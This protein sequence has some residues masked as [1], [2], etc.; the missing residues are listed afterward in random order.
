MGG[1][2]LP[3]SG[4]AGFA[5]VLLLALVPAPARAQFGYSSEFE[6]SPL[7]QVREPE[8]AARTHL[9]RI[10]VLLADEQWDE[11]VETL[12][13][14]METEGDR[15][16]ALAPEHYITVRDY[17]HLQIAQLPPP[18]LELY[19]DRVDPLAKQWYEQGAAERDEELLAR[20]VDQLFCSSWGDNAL[21]KLGEMALARGDFGRARA[22]WERLSPLLRAPDGRPWSVLRDFD[23]ADRWKELEPLLAKRDSPPKWL[24]FPDTEFPLADVRARLALVSIFEGSRERAV[25]ELELLR[26]LHPDAKGRWAGREV[27][28]V[29]ELERLLAASADWP[30][31][32]PARDWTTF[33]G[34]PDRATRLPPA[35]RP[36]G[37][38]WEKPI[39]LG[40][41]L[42][43]DEGFGRNFGRE[44]RRP[45]E[46][47][48]QL[49][50]Y[51]PL[52]VGNLLLVNDE[53]R[54]RA[55]DLRTGKP[56]WGQEDG[57]IFKDDRPD[58]GARRRGR[59]RLGVPRFTMTAADGKLFARMGEPI[60]SWPA[61]PTRAVQEGY[62]VCL[63]LEAQ[64]QLLWKITADEPRDAKGEWTF[65]GAPVSAGG[66]VYVAL[67]RGDVRPQ[68][69]VACYDAQTGR[70]L[71]RQ[72]VCAA[73]TPGRG[74]VEEITSNLLTLAEGTLYYNTNLGA[75]ASLAAD[76]GRIHWLSLYERADGGNL[77]RPAAHFYRDLTPCVYYRGVVVAAPSDSEYITAFDAGSGARLWASRWPTD[78]VHL[79]GV[80]GGHLIASGNRLWW[81]DV[82]SGNVVRRWPENDKAGPGG[83][84]RGVLAGGEIYWPTRDRVY[85]FDAEKAVPSQEPIPLNVYHADGGNL[86]AIKGYFL[87]AASDRLYGLGPNP[88][89][90]QQEPHEVTGGVGAHRRVARRAV[91]EIAD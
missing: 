29:E 39:E 45:A 41:P 51:H 56:A 33:A 38:A 31:S 36:A 28:Y 3:A 40:E 55:F 42:V 47:A 11:A 13:Q 78:A 43:V 57:V 80:S 71:W 54:I 81:L 49:L 61:E 77:S 63:D 35:K 90:K 14:L 79:L 84:G 53:S 15:L 86:L 22:H 16:F 50:P 76:D 75:V 27:N 4:V 48:E 7:V 32:P 52:V 8:G 87:I 67:R 6:L 2:R 73:E 46:D 85:V 83:Y 18:A 34:S 25:V 69:Y 58:F 24:A 66:R 89:S 9:E 30:A 65:E 17:C 74:Q 62:L 88:R 91:G 21:W 10:K 70:E 72:F 26:R 37:P 12:R 1:K 44:G 19:R 64:G 5:A 68:A 82:Y 23:I 20:V 59:G 60:T